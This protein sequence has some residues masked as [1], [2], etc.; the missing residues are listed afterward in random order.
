MQGESATLLRA[1]EAMAQG[2]FRLERGQN[3]FHNAQAQAQKR[4]VPFKWRLQLVPGVAHSD[5]GMSKAAVKLF[6]P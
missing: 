6:F 5:S 4:Q 2:R 3:F 1:P